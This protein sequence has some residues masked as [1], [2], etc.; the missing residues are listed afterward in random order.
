MSVIFYTVLA[1]VL[2]IAYCWLFRI[3]EQITETAKAVQNVRQLNT[4][5][6]QLHLYLVKTNSEDQSFRQRQQLL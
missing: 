1:V 5:L 3:N 4:K 2:R 6:E